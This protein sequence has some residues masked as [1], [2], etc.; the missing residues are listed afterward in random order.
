MA[1]AY[2]PHSSGRMKYPVLCHPLHCANIYL[3]KDCPLGHSTG[4]H[5]ESDFNK[6]L[7]NP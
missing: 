5:V 2:I 1:S 4:E 3:V 7:S 6:G